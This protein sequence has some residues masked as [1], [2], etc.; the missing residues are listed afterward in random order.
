[1]AKI[2][3]LGNGRAS[4]C[5]ERDYEWTL[6]KM[7]HTVVF[8]QETEATGERILEESVNAD[9]LFW[10]H[11]HKW[12]T[13]GLSMK[14]VLGNL[15]RSNIPSFAYH[16]D[17]WLGIEREKDM[18]DDYFL[19]E[20]F[21][22]VDGEMA[23]YLNANTEVNGHYL[24]AGVV[25]RDCYLE[26]PQRGFFGDV[27]FTGSYDYHEE[28]PYR[29]ELINFLRKTYGMKFRRWGRAAKDQ[30]NARYIMGSDLNKLLASVK[31]V[32]GDTLCPNFTKPYYFSNRSFETTGKGGFLIHPYVKGLEECF[33]LEKELVTYEYG[34]FKQLKEKID[35]FLLHPEERNAIRIAGHERTKKDHTFTNRLNTMLSTIGVTHE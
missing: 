18:A 33:E 17:L 9:A 28:W 31:I 5:S 7:G 13:P 10:V 12:E 34:N 26:K 35:Y 2:V 30:P 1:M 3:L 6:K 14:N 11:T 21:F 27:I 24:P 19:V 23:E 4:Y 29:K 15:K 20:H 22:T 32:V 25:E 16:L 8:L